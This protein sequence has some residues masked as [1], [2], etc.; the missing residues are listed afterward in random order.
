MTLLAQCFNTLFF[1]AFPYSVCNGSWVQ[2]RSIRDLKTSRD[3][4]C[5]TEEGSEFQSLIARNV[6]CMPSDI[7]YYLLTYIPGTPCKLINALQA[8]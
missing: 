7:I 5:T 2:W 3:D 6:E 1:L 4:E 8:L